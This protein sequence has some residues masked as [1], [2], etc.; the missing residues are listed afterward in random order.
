MDFH[1]FATQFQVLHGWIDCH[2]LWVK[3]LDTVFE[4]KN[5]WPIIEMIFSYLGV[6]EKSAVIIVDL[7]KKMAHISHFIERI[8]ADKT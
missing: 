8:T 2:I 6:H 4:Y 5:S 3:I 7:G 1:P